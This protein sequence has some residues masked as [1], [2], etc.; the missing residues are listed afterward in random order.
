VQELVEI[1]IKYAGYVDRARSQ[2]AQLARLEA[3]PLPGSV[4]YAA[5]PGLSAEAS[6]KLERVQPRTVAQAAR[7]PGVSPADLGVLMIRLRQTGLLPRGPK[8]QKGS[9]GAA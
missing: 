4:P 2:I 9:A 6:Q 7:I 8:G 1:E 3:M 5:M